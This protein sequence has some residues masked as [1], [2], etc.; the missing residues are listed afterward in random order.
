MYLDIKGYEGYRISQSGK[1]QRWIKYRKRW[2]DVL[3]QPDSN[4]RYKT[5]T[6]WKDGKRKVFMLHNLVADNFC[7]PVEDA[8]RSCYNGYLLTPG[9]KDNVREFILK[10][11]EARKKEGKIDESKYLRECLDVLK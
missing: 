2:E 4:K 10:A 11:I 6:L 8:K 5:V 1:V 7:I 9:A 3:P